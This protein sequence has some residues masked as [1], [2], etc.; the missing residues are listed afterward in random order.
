MRWELMGT[1]LRDGGSVSARGRPRRDSTPV[2]ARGRTLNRLEV[3]GTARAAFHR[4]ARAAPV[5][6]KGLLPADGVERDEHRVEENRLPDGTQARETAAIVRGQDGTTVLN[7]SEAPAAPWCRRE[8]PAGHT[9]RGVWVPPV[10]EE[11]GNRR[12]R[13][14][15]NS[16]AAGDGLISPSDPEAQEAT[17]RDTGG[18]GSAVHLTDIGDDAF[19]HLLP[20]VE[21]TPAPGS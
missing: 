1:R 16:S 18:V 2:L 5:W 19:P 17:K 13:S 12:W 6:Q 21:T 9:G 8:R 14:L 15:T 11:E 7:A 20:P 10:L 3:V 4:V